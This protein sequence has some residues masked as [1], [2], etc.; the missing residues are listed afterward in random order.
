MFAVPQH[1]LAKECC[2]IR[3]IKVDGDTDKKTYLLTIIQLLIDL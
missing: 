1:N 2:S 3:Q